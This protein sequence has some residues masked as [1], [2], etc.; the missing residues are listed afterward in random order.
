MVRTQPVA[1]MGAVLVS[2]PQLSFPKVKTPCE[3]CVLLSA[4]YGCMPSVFPEGAPYVGNS[5]DEATPK[6]W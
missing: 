1:H 5:L 3:R 6:T 2:P 4:Y